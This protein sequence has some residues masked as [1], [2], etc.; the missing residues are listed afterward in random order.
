VALLLE[1]DMK[2][3]AMTLTPVIGV[4]LPNNSVIGIEA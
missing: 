3:A 4:L 2:V 1:V